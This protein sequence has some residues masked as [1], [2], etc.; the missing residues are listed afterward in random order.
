MLYPTIPAADDPYQIWLTIR[1]TRPKVIHLTAQHNVIL[2]AVRL[3]FDYRAR[4]DACRQVLRE[5]ANIPISRP[6]PKAILSGAITGSL[7]HPVMTPADINA[8]ATFLS[9]ALELQ[10]VV[11]MKGKIKPIG[12]GQVL[13]WSIDNNYLAK[14]TANHNIDEQIARLENKNK[15]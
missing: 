1:S 12:D 6:T 9:K 11:V 8:I 10:V 7:Y 2:E 14:L 13:L 5:R 3:T 4:A 15:Y